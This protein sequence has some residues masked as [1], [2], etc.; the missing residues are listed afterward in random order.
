MKVIEIIHNAILL[1][2]P[3]MHSNSHHLSTSRARRKTMGEE[4]VRIG[5]KRWDAEANS[6]RVARTRLGEATH[7]SFRLYHRHKTI[8]YIF[9]MDNFLWTIFNSEFEFPPHIDTT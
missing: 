6:F 2:H 7:R 1:A 3:K 9:K 4:M 8:V 5:C